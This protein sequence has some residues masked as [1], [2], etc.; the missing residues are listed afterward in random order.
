MSTLASAQRVSVPRGCSTFS[1]S[2]EPMNCVL[3]VHWSRFVGYGRH[4][5]VVLPPCEPWV[6]TIRLKVCMDVTGLS[7]GGRAGSRC[8][9]FA[10]RGGGCLFRGTADV[11]CATHRA[12]GCM[13]RLR[14]RSGWDMCVVV[15]TWPGALRSSTPTLLWGSTSASPHM[16][17]E[18]RFLPLVISGLQLP[19]IRIQ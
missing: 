11:A 17:I 7:L 8:P 6:S 9:L 15:R 5:L 16:S 2:P 19:G 3:V 18:L 14:T 4:V 12:W 10:Q 1:S 13:S